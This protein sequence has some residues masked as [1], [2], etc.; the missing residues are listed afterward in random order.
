MTQIALLDT[1]TRGFKNRWGT[2]EADPEVPTTTL[3]SFLADREIKFQK[4]GLLK[5]L[6]LV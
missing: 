1:P 6:A 5:L 3:M 2:R 4:N